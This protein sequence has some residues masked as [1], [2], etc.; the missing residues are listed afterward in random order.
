MIKFTLR[1]GLNSV[2]SLYEFTRKLIII[3]VCRYY[4]KNTTTSDQ[5]LEGQTAIND[6]AKES[7]VQL[8]DLN[9]LE[10]AT[11]LMVNNFTTFRQIGKEDILFSKR[12]YT[13][14]FLL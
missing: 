14:I 2:K 3:S 4:I 8:L 13:K 5:L 6:L 10:L 9:A 1:Q 11:Q 7:V 12:P